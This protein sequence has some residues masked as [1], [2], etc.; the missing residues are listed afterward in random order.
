VVKGERLALEGRSAQVGGGGGGG[1][2]EIEEEACTM[3][4]VLEHV[5]LTCPACTT[6]AARTS[7][8]SSAAF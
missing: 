5:R 7:V 1:G 4:L 8:D 2:M 6:S 3:R